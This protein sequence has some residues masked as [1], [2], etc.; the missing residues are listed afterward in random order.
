M[1]VSKKRLKQIIKEE[2]ARVNEEELNADALHA[3]ALE[4]IS[5]IEPPEAQAV[6]LE[7]IRLLRG[8]K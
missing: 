8:N 2:L 5:T 7:Y 4:A 1:K 6:V 3:K